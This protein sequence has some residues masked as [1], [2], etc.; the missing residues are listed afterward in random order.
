MN[1]GVNPAI[2][3]RINSGM[4]SGL[5]S[6]MHSDMD[7]G[8]SS[9]IGSVINSESDSRMNSGMNSEIDWRFQKW[10]NRRSAK[11]RAKRLKHIEN[12]NR[13]I[14]RLEMELVK[15]EEALEEVL[16]KRRLLMTR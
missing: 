5:D 16:R 11:E 14:K 12:L 9:E 6:G 2:S 15:E 13:R 1:S 7:S 3:S 8:M 10:N 4:N